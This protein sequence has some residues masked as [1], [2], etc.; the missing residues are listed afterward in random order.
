M[1][2][3]WSLNSI[4]KKD[5]REILLQN[6]G[7][8]SFFKLKTNDLRKKNLQTQKNRKLDRKKFKATVLGHLIE[9]DLRTLKF[10]FAQ[11][12]KTQERHFKK[13]EN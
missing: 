7:S 6:K 1:E 4:K 13:K 8:Q 9:S 12:L 2:N 10:I 11:K 5:L 3:F